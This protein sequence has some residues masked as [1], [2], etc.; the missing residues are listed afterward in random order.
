MVSVAEVLAY[1]H[2]V[3]EIPFM[4]RLDPDIET[5][6]LSGV[7]QDEFAGSGDLSWLSPSQAQRDPERVQRFRGTLLI[8]P[9][10]CNRLA[11]G[12]LP[13]VVPCS[14]PKYAF[15]IVV[16]QFFNDLV[17]TRWP[18]S[19]EPS[20]ARDA[21][22]G[23]DVVLGA[24]AVIG[25]DTIIGDEVVIGPNTCI[26][27][28]TVQS[29]VRIGGNCS[30]GFQGFGYDRAP[31]G[32][33]IRFPHLGRVVIEEGV[34]IGSNTCID[35]G[36]LGETRIGRGAKID[37]LVHIAHNVVVGPE[38]LVIANSMLGGSVKI[39]SEVWIAPSV[40]VMNQVE[41]GAGAVLGMG[42]VVLKSV[43]AGETVV[44]NPARSLTTRSKP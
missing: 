40:S 33:Y 31:N 20:V 27:H 21:Q 18:Q 3:E 11:S 38:T 36:A 39:D 5:A 13:V 2:R 32:G 28:A 8:A 43:L 26:A 34:D 42:A 22:I 30:I 17:E 10:F 41:I 35:R 7:K 4:P 15:S 23:R 24:G 12:E 6:K 29:N 37:N 19:R 9:Q 14:H 16:L 25:P 44:G 1:L